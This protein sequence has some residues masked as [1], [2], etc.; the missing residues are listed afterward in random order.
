MSRETHARGIAAQMAAR[1][2]V[3]KKVLGYCCGCAAY[4]TQGMMQDRE[5]IPLAPD[6]YLCARCEGGES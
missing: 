4:V 3:R 5:A 6:I 1:Q 2:D